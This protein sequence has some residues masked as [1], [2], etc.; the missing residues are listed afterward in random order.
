VTLFLYAHADR[1]APGS[2]Q[3]PVPIPA[4][5]PGSP[6]FVQ[7][8]FNKDWLPY[9]LGC[10]FQLTLSTTWSAATDAELKNALQMANDLILIFQL[11]QPGCDIKAP[12]GEGTTGDDMCCCLRMQDGMLQVFSC[13]EWKTV[14]GWDPAAIAPRQPGSGSPQPASGQCQSFSC[15]LGPTTPW[16][17]PV[18]VSSG[19]TIT[20]SNLNGS[21][22]PSAFTEIWLCPDGNLFVAGF[23]VDHTQA[24]DAGA[25]M[26]SAPL[27]GTILFDGTNY[28]D[29]SAA[30]NLDT[31]V[32]VTIAPGVSNAQLL[33]R[34]NFHGGVDPAGQVLG[35]IQ[36][37]NNQAAVWSHTL[38]FTTSNHSFQP[39]LAGGVTPTATWVVGQG[40]RNVNTDGFDELRIWI[41]G[42]VS[43]S[44]SFVK[45]TATIAHALNEYAAG[46]GNA[47]SITVEFPAIAPVGPGTNVVS[48]QGTTPYT[49]TSFRIDLTDTGHSTVG[50]IFL[51]SLTV[52]GTG[53]DPFSAL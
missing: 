41:D 36:V 24:F 29:V 21:W 22:S 33:V 16:L 32:T 31:P 14:D 15:V 51:T 20:V 13:G 1:Q 3:Q 46:S 35:N 49:A 18:A 5:K 25:P 30:A 2:F 19:D 9:I 43:T 34:C 37:C 26:P 27:N 44:Y 4:S 7:V 6:D 50:D 28:Y 40:W 17:L 53:P 47:G 52:S 45:A 11:A 42:L 8:C 48:S 10:L 23:C 39:A 38:D 12:G